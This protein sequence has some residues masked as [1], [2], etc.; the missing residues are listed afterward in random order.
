[1]KF[2]III[3]GEFMKKF[4]LASLI[5]LST[6]L[7]AFAVYETNSSEAFVPA[8]ITRFFHCIP[9][10]SNQSI[11]GKE[12]KRSVIGWENYKCKFT[13]NIK[14]EK[15]N[16]NYTCSLTRDQVNQLTSAMKSDPYA[17]AEA[18]TLL[19]QFEKDTSICTKN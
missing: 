14:T 7:C 3:S 17:T 6:S 10:V 15:E 9:A 2:V 18:K 13:E 11:E 8:Y 1:M 4:I 19:E 12:I 16:V 5:L